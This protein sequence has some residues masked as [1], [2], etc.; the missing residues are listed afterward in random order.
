MSVKVISPIY[1]LQLGCFFLGCS[2]SKADQL[3]AYAWWFLCRQCTLP[4]FFRKQDRDALALQLQAQ[5]LDVAT[6]DSC[7]FK[8]GLV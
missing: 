3:E 2:A 7:F 1:V 8:L 6:V 4:S 5:G